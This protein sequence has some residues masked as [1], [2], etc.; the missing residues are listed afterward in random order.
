PWLDSAAPLPSPPA[1]EELLTRIVA[2]LEDGNSADEFEL[3]IAAM[4]KTRPAEVGTPRSLATIGR[5]ATTLEQRRRDPRVFPFAG[6]V[7]CWLEGSTE[8]TSRLEYLTTARG[9]RPT[10]LDL[11]AA[12]RFDELAAALATGSPTELMATPTHTGGVL[13]PIEFARRASSVFDGGG[14]PCNADLQVALLRLAPLPD[15]LD[16]ASQILR[17]ESGP[18]AE[19][20]REWIRRWPN[21]CDAD[22]TRAVARQVLDHSWEAQGKT[23]RSTSLNVPDSGR[24]GPGVDRENTM[25]SFDHHD[26]LSFGYRSSLLPASSGLWSRRIALML[27]HS[28]GPWAEDEPSTADV[29]ERFFD[30][31]CPFGPGQHLALALALAA[32]GREIRG[33]GTD[34]LIETMEDGRCDADLLGRELGQL[35]QRRL[36]ITSRWVEAVDEAMRSSNVCMGLGAEVLQSAVAHTDAS[37]PNRILPVLE[38]LERAV[39]VLGVSVDNTRTRAVLDGLVGSSKSGRAARRLLSAEAEAVEGSSA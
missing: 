32:K 8:W 35:T 2:F 16:R 37:N 7:R 13:A 6:L 33:T 24:F 29:L 19:R 3:L 22:E 34:L 21:H 10:R 36:L 30:P 18:L 14:A 5:R 17:G 4:L 26:T 1:A 27:S 31:W 15:D 38:T 12:E 25:F 28:A 23:Y 11:I 39:A 20:I 9:W